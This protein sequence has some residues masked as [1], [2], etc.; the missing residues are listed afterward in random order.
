MVKER[1]N[2]GGPKWGLGLS[3]EKEMRV[4]G[5]VFGRERERER[6]R[7]RKRERESKG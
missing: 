5:L 7:E 2:K 3:V 1:K 4:V 6:E